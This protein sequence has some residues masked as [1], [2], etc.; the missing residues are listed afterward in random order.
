M[1]GMGRSEPEKPKTFNCYTTLG[2]AKDAD[3]KA[4]R[5]AY[6][7]KSRKGPQAHPDRGGD[8]KKFQELQEAYETLKNKR[9]DYDK[10]GDA[11]L[12]PDWE[13]SRAG[14]M[15]RRQEQQRPKA[16]PVAMTLKVSLA[17][18]YNGAEKK[19]SFSRQVFLSDRDG[20]VA[21]GDGTD[22]YSDCTTCGGQG[23]VIRR[24]Q[25][26]PGYVVQ[27][28]VHC[29][30]C[31]GRCVQLTDGWHLGK[32][33]ET[34]SVF[35]EKGSKKGDKLK[36]RDKG[37]MH[38]GASVGDVV[39]K[40]ECEPH[41][42]F[43][44]KGADLLWQKEIS[45]VDALCGF[46]FE[47][48]HLDGRKVIVQS[49]PGEV[50]SDEAV[51]VLRGEG[52]PVKGD[53]GETGN[54]FFEFA[55]E[56]PKRGEL[57]A[58]QQSQ[59][60]TVLTGVPPAK[61]P[62]TSAARARRTLTSANRTEE[63]TLRAKLLTF[64]QK[65]QSWRDGKLKKYDNEAATRAD[66]NK[67]Y[68]TRTGYV[69]FLDQTISEKLG[70]ERKKMKSKCSFDVDLSTS[71]RSKVENGDIS[72]E[73]DSD[74]ET[75]Y[76]QEVSREFFGQKTAEIQK[77]AADSSDSDEEGRGRGGGGAQRCEVQ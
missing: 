60:H 35:I 73:E 11:M 52:F 32:V 75:H 17:D 15:S 50:V 16:P 13:Q 34:L 45:L 10:Y 6:L 74:D 37:N 47:F 66:R 43:K 14:Q 18:L 22:L 64:K 71:P 26:Q 25:V 49:G 76:L 65:L 55:V 44:R 40:L 29:P 41:P 58:S 36:F 21:P 46:N 24:Q 53:D 72:S 77:G 59:L 5:K 28:Q 23:A 12:K 39:V 69:G 63:T 68:H 67:K 33:R 27:R 7:M 8:P 48:T 1:G 38:P 3:Q 42:F 2:V 9:Q 4:V 57:S 30:A 20:K 62:A 31:K 56:I 61:R 19:V 51:K 54:L 70:G